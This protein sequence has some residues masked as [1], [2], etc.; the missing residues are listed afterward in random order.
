L[1]SFITGIDFWA[2]DIGV[3]LIPANT[4]SKRTYEEWSQWQD[5]PIP[6]EILEEWK[7]NGKFDQGCAIIAGKIWRGPYK[8]K[9]LCCIDIDNKS[10]FDNFLQQFGDN[11]TL[12]RLT[13]KTIVEW[14]PDD[15]NRAHIYFIVEKP[16]SKKSGIYSRNDLD[17][18]TTTPAI[19][20]KSE[21]K[22]GIMYCSPSFHKDGYQYAIIGTKVPAVLNTDQSQELEN[23]INQI[24]VKHGSL[25]QEQEK[26]HQTPIQELFK[27]EFYVYQ[28]MNR[29]EC[30]L[31][32][33][34]S[35]IQRNRTILTE[36]EIKKLSHE[37][38]QKHCS[39][40]LN[41]EEVDRQWRDAIRFIQKNSNTEKKKVEPDFP[42]L[43]ITDLISSIK[44]RCIEIFRDQINVYYATI[45]INDHVES[46]PLHSSRFKNIIRKEF[47]DKTGTVISDDKLDGLLKLIESQ[48]M[49]DDNIRRINLSLRVAM[50]NQDK[51]NNNLAFIY[52]LTTSKWEFVKVSADEGWK[53]I[54]DN[55]EP[56]FKRY[57]NN[58]CPQIY[59]SR[60][61][62][63]NIFEK[64]LKLFNFQ[65]KKDILL[66]SVYLVSLFIPE[67]PKV[68][69]IIRG[70]GGGAKTTAFRMIKEIVDPSSVDTFSF[71]KQINDLVQTL[72]HHYVNFFD[73]V[74][75]I[76]EE[77][78][79]LLCRTVTGSGNMKRALYTTDTDFIYKYKRCIGIN[80]INLAST[81]ADFLDRSLIIEVK[82]IEKEK[83]RKEEELNGEFQELKPLLLGFIFDLL[84][85]V[86]KYRQGHTNEQILKNG[87]PR[88]A[89]FA[90]WGEIISRCL[91]YEDNEFLNAYYENIANQNDEV[92]ESSPVA[93][94]LLLFMFEMEK[95]FWEGSPTR[96]YRELTDIIDQIKPELKRSNEW[97]KASNKLTSIL[98][99]V[100]NNLKEK[101]IEVITGE[102]DTHGNRII[103]IHNLS[104]N[105]KCRVSEDNNVV[106]SSNQ[107]KDTIQFNPNIHRKGYSDNFECGLCPLVGDIHL[108]KSHICS[109]QGH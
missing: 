90:E 57:E 99:S 106:N 64:F 50:I 23:R 92:I 18:S 63:N 102:R 26:I 49:F 19:E 71:P 34:E 78:S 79:D 24:Y 22:H 17:N 62:P 39:P 96:L 16:L 105:I 91:G 40:P 86:L 73:N 31:R 25:P 11:Y 103:K 7:K 66:F 55:Q 107:E 100:A 29:H 56:I 76:S 85:K 6:N 77:V 15:K 97:P 47:F 82:R 9:Y 109:G 61:Y 104:K 35:L 36:D 51:E 93:E 81:R 37:W 33:M 53:I 45:R 95:E 94:A 70:T 69:L 44:E 65:S 3:N 48:S 4:R 12:E 74:S 8:G 67:I 108:M 83:R 38:N 32:V 1:T 80:G 30:M 42:E 27:N 58:C 60:E 5:K 43:A 101:G 68:I 59:P 84:V 10:G 21:G 98:N 87:Y 75:Y 54:K 13:E 88:M 89:D 20:V 46:I 28:G 52:D 14:H 72:D 2:H 41:D